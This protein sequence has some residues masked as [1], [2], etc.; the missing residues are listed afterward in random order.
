MS[1]SLR[2]TLRAGGLVE[3][4]DGAWVRAEA[5]AGLE[6]EVA[7]LRGIL[8]GAVG[9][10]AYDCPCCEGQEEHSEDC[11]YLEDTTGEVQIALAEV[12]R[13]RSSLLRA[14]SMLSR[15]AQEAPTSHQDER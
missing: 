1:K 5:V 13:I 11:T 10:L 2:Y 12:W 4:A 6:A 14:L 9:A 8:E 7:R 3:C 15:A